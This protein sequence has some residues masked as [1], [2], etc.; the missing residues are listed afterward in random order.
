MCVLRLR[1]VHYSLYLKGTQSQ[2][3]H[4]A[5]DL[6]YDTRMS[7]RCQFLHTHT[8]TRIIHLI[9]TSPPPSRRWK[10]EMSPLLISPYIERFH[11]GCNAF[12]ITIFNEVESSCPVKDSPRYYMGLEEGLDL[13]L[14]RTGLISHCG[15]VAHLI[16]HASKKCKSMIH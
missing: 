3:N 16:A 8:I 7:T 5:S 13:S 11:R 4:V 14:F 15:V 2:T 9:S 1:R 12:T 6:V 10:D